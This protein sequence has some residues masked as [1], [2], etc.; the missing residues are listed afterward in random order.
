MGIGASSERVMT[1][2]KVKIAL[3]YRRFVRH[4]RSHAE[5]LANAG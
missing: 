1:K 2:I 5:R 3:V 4:R